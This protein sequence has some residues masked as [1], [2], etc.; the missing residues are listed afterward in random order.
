MA[1]RMLERQIKALDA[2]ID[3]LV[4]ALYALTDEEIKVGRAAPRRPGMNSC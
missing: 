3:A 4:Y 1:K 2:Q